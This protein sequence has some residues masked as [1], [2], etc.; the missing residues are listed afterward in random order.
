MKN[1]LDQCS[2]FRKT[3]VLNNEEYKII[4]ASL[5]FVLT[6]VAELNLDEIEA[7]NSTLD[8]LVAPSNSENN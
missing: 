1:N 7:I 2:G 6:S 3:I 5:N 4:H 8:K